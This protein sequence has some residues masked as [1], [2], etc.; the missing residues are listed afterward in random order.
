[1]DMLVQKILTKETDPYSVADMLLA[2]RL[3]RFKTG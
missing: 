1:L 3:K 2:K